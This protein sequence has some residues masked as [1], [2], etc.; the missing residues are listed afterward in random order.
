MKLSI[1]LGLAGCALL[2]LAIMGITVTLPTRKLIVY[3]PKD[4]QEA[5]LPRL[6]ALPLSP[7]RVLG[8]LI[9][10]LF[11]LGYAGLFV[12]GALDGLRQGFGFQDFFLR[13][14]IMTAI[15]KAFDILALDY[16]LLTRT[17]FF[18]HFFPET[19]GC[20][21]WKD[22]GY[23]RGQQLKRLLFLPLLDALLAWLLTLL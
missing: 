21:G 15:I 12:L 16:F 7:K 3:F 8:F 14:L 22:F 6:E 11:G 4:V 17:R 20:K 19:N 13:F 1:L 9:L 5:L 10:V 2:F 23:N 18:R